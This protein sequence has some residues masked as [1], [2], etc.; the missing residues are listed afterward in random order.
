MER[1][2]KM[3]QITITSETDGGPFL[4]KIGCQK[5]FYLTVDGLIDELEAYLE[6]PQRSQELYA[7]VIMQ[8]EAQVP[9]GPPVEPIAYPWVGTPG[10]AGTSNLGQAVGDGGSSLRSRR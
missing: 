7:K 9:T 6:N 5:F 1:R 4:V 3:H 2:D 10:P 8:P